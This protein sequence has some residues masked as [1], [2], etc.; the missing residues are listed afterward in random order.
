[1]RIFTTKSFGRFCRKAGITDEALG[2]TVEEIERGLIDADLGGGVL[3]KRI[4]R[5][6][7][8]KSGGF[9]TLLAFRSGDRT[10]FIFGFA[11][12]DR[13]NISSSQLSSLKEAAKVY[14]GLTDDEIEEALRAGALREVRYGEE[15]NDEEAD[16][17][18]NE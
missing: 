7:G 8:G 9:R 17:A 16:G 1:M 3:K 14:L 5:D 13:D 2:R 12:S 10:V 15:E 11:K 4:A 18:E 6:G